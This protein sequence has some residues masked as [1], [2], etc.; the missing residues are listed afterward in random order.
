MTGDNASVTSDPFRRRF[1]Q[2]SVA[3]FIALPGLA[4]AQ[5]PGGTRRVAVLLA[6]SPATAS[7]LVKALADGLAELGWVEGRN[8]HLDVRYGENDAARASGGLPPSSWRSGRMFL[9]RETNRL[10]GRSL[11]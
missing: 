1:L 11:R 9:S 7:H 8:L 6:S 10:P 3:A 2:Y 4:M 5:A